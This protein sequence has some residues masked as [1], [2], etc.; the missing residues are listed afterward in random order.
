MAHVMTMIVTETTVRM[1]LLRNAVTS[2]LLFAEKT[3]LMFC[4]IGQDFGKANDSA[5]AS[6]AVLD[7]VRNMNTNGTMNRQMATSTAAISVLV[8]RR[9][10]TV[11][12]RGS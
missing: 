9:L 8:R 5:A 6:S 12:P 7:A 11:P 1:M 4:Q 10:L 2:S 3:S